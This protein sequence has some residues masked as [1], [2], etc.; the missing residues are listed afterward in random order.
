M[1]A[2][3]I[4]EPGRV[5]VREI[6]RPDP[7]PGEVLVK[8]AACGI[9]GT[10]VHIFRGEYLGEYPIVPGHEF[11]GEVVE[12]GEGVSR[13][14]VGQRV[15][16]E[17]NISCDNCV[18]CL[19]N[20]QNFCLNWEAIGVT[21]QGAMAE[22]VVAPEKVVFDIGDLAFEEGAFVE[23]LSCVVHGIERAQIRLGDRIVILGAG[24]IG[25]LLLQVAKRRGAVDI[26]V[27]ERQP[28]RGQLAQV[29]GADRWIEDL[30]ALE[31]D[32]YDV[33]IDASGALPVMARTLS[34]VRNGGT[35]LLFGV[36]PRGGE[37]PMDAFAIFEKGVTIRSS[38][39]SRRNSL[40]AVAMLQSGAVAVEDLVSHCLPLHR[41]EDGVR[42]IE[43]GLEDVKK[44]LMIPNAA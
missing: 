36:P 15:A 7:G 3:T 23:P 24:P 1:K 43:K 11:S 21:L 29:Y 25:L 38:Y 44:V 9:C 39:T 2:L 13:I 41:F 19:N 30:E 28:A 16:V 10:D 26:T 14:R 37:L 12:V 40:Q 31:R 5:E 20:R 34:L 35:I 4:L 42:F 17:P 27:L 18:S 32:A 8:V 33:V 6:P 22:Y